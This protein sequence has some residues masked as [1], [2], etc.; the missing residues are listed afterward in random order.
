MS[1]EIIA[2]FSAGKL[3]P[4][5]K[6]LDPQLGKSN[7]S[8]AAAIPILLD[9]ATC[10]EQLGLHRKAL[11]VLVHPI[12]SLILSSAVAS[13]YQHCLRAFVGILRCIALAAAA[14][15]CKARLV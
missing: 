7:L 6:L 11:K 12:N 5:I 4:A 15:F 3:A 2:A 1:S 10:N 13:S 9:R 14:W 8:D